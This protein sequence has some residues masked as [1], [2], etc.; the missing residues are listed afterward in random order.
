MVAGGNGCLVYSKP[1]SALCHDYSKQLFPVDPYFDK[2]FDQGKPRFDLIDPQFELDLANVMAHGAQK[3]EANS[4]QT[5]PDATNRYRAALRRHLNA[6]ELGELIDPDS[7]L[8]HTA[9]ISA[10]AMFLSYLYRS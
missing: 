10:N 7:G 8:P 2:K 9:H 6:I 4:W 5:V 3:Y 1:N